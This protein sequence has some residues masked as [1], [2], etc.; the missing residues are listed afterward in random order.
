[1]GHFGQLVSLLTGHKETVQ[2]LLRSLTHLRDPFVPA[3]VTAR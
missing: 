2:D 1:M 3:V